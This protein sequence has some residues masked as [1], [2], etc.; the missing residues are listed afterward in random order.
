MKWGHLSILIIKRKYSKASKLLAWSEQRCFNQH[1]LRMFEWLINLA[2]TWG[3]CD[4]ST[5]MENLGILRGE[6]HILTLPKVLTE[7]VRFK[8]LNLILVIFL[9]WVWGKNVHQITDEIYLVHFIIEVSAYYHAIL[10][11]YTLTMTCSIL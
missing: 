5:Q 7:Y 3:F 11:C 1:T 9:P 6:L 4:L 2:A 8:S 10:T